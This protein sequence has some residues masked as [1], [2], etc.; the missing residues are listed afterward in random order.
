MTVKS[1]LHVTLHVYD[2]MRSWSDLQVYDI[3]F[4]TKAYLSMINSQSKKQ[5][6]HFENW[7]ITRTSLKEMRPDAPT[8]KHL[9]TRKV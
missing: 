8:G 6:E 2:S 7:Q 5:I 3:I 1:T 9:H 4:E